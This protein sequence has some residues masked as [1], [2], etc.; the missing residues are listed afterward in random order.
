MAQCKFSAVRYSSIL[1]DTLVRSPLLVLPH[2][3]LSARCMSLSLAPN[4]YGLYWPNPR[5]TFQADTDGLLCRSGHDAELCHV[6]CLG[7]NPSP[8]DL[9]D[10]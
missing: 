5:S 7:M 1:V 2:F 4:S 9:A 8:A 6:P 10:P 3:P